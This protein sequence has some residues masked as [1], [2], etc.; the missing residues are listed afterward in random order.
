MRHHALRVVLLGLMVWT[1]AGC[2]LIFRGNKQTVEVITDPPAATLVVDKKTYVTPAK[3][4]ISRKKKYDVTLTKPGYQ[5][6]HFVFKPRWD[7]GGA[8]AVAFDAIVPGGSVLFVIDTLSGADREFNK[9]ATIK[10]PP[11]TGPTTGPV[12]LYEHKGKL[13]NKE[14]YDKKV[15]EDKLFGKKS[16]KDKKK[17]KDAPTTQP[18]Q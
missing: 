3:V 8:G 16:K 10:L 9:I 6:I 1:S 4:L 11:A 15:E 5:G 7:G 2:G 12:T 14:D 17:S 18:S 13:Y